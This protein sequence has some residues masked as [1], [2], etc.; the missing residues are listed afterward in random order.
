MKIHP[1]E[2]CHCMTL[3]KAARRISQMYDEALAPTGLGAAQFAMLATLS[4]RDRMNINELAE[5]LDL[6][7]TTTGKNLR[8]LER[9]GLIAVSTSQ[10][11]R[12][13]RV[14]ALTARGRSKLMT[15]YPLWS[16]AQERFEAANGRRKT[17]IMRSDLGELKIESRLTI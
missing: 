4:A 16:S 13:S 10:E 6:D 17:R 12:R 14:I 9:D 1:I 8:P 7:R 3:R 11:D 5:Q 15:A 2:A